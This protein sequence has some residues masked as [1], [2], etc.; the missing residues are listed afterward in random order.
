MSDYNGSSLGLAVI[1]GELRAESRHTAEALKTINEGIERQND[2]LLDLPAQIA[3]KIATPV[4][5]NPSRLRETQGVL[6][7]IPPIFKTAAVLLAVIG[8]M[9]QRLAW[10]DIPK[11]FGPGEIVSPK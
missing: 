8:L 3:L 5:A 7:S 9:T 10:S 6:K 4:S 2:I 1:L 11:L